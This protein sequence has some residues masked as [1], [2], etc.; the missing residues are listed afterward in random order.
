MANS[1]V[2]EGFYSTVFLV[3]K[4]EGQFRPVINLRSLNR[5][6]RHQH[7]KMEGIHLLRDILQ[8]GDWLCR[9]DLK[10]AYFA[11]LI[12]PAHQKLLRFLW[13][14]SVYQF[15]CLPFGLSSAP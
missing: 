11:V 15:T 12:I 6:I 5:F 4:K 10:D 9:R 3:P 7:F 13:N 14:K 2:H 1:E 8:R